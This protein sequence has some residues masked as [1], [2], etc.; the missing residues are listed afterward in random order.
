MPKIALITKANFKKKN[1][2]SPKVHGPANAAY[3]VFPEDSTDP[4]VKILQIDTYGS[5]NRVH[6]G[7]VS[8]SIQ[9]DYESAKVLFD[10]L[11]QEFKFEV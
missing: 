1:S 7:K 5:I 4:K 2:S 11:V 9:F 10:L 3:F 8:Q 6:Q